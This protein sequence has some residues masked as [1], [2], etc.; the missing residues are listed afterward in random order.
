MTKFGLTVACCPVGLG[1]EPGQSSSFTWPG[2]VCNVGVDGLKLADV[3]PTSEELGADSSSLWRSLILCRSSFRYSIA[4]PRIEALSIYHSRREMLMRINSRIRIKKQT[5]LM[6]IIMLQLVTYLSI[7]V[8]QV[9]LYCSKPSWSV[10]ASW[11][12]PNMYVLWWSSFQACVHCLR[13][14]TIV[15]NKL[16]PAKPRIVKNKKK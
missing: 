16:K 12:I 13:N 9:F 2:N 1:N 5:S 14:I 10:K 15:K 11:L 8:L 3:G 6:Q 7:A 4:S